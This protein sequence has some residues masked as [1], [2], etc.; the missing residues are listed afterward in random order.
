MNN[1]KSNTSEVIKS[2][3]REMD[4]S[5]IIKVMFS[6]IWII[7]TFSVLGLFIGYIY[8]HSTIFADSGETQFKIRIPVYELG[9]IDQLKLN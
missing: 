1:I 5:E 2:Y 3:I 4:L 7:L 6:G 8:Q 9:T